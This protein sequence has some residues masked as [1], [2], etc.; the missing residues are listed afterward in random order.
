MNNYTLRY[1]IAGGIVSIAL[2]LLNWF[3]VAQWFGPIPSQT[4]GWLSIIL[5]LMCVPLGIRYFRDKLN[6]GNVSFGQ[7]FRI[8]FGITFVV[9]ALM[10][11]YSALFFIFQGEEFIEWTKRGLSTAEVAAYEQQIAQTPA[12]VYTP[13]VQAF[14]LFVSIML[15]GLVITAISSLILKRSGER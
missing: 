15:I 11:F 5:S 10:Y 4:V 7:G 13:W 12:W 8:G 2:G 6:D 14:L 3:T 1:G 9:S